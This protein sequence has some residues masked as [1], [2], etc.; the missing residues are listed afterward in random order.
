MDSPVKPGNDEMK[1]SGDKIDIVS[2]IYKII[3]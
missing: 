3:S 1:Y 2:V